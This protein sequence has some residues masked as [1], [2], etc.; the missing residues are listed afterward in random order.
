VASEIRAFAQVSDRAM[1]DYRAVKRE[2]SRKYLKSSAVPQSARALRAA[3]SP[4]PSRNVVGVGIAEKLVDN[5]PAGVLSIK[6]LVRSK[7]PESDISTS[8]ALPKMV[9]GLPTDVEEVGLI[10][11]LARKSAPARR[12]SSRPAKKAAAGMPDPRQKIRPAQPGCS[13]GFR[14]PS[15]QFVM[16]GTFGAL[17]RD[18]AGLYVLSNNHVLADEDQLAPGAPIFQPGLLDGGNPATDQIAELTRAV[19]LITTANMKV[20]GAVARA[21]RANLV[22]DEI[23]F[24]GRPNGT[25]Q[26][27]RDMIVHKF[28]RTT[29]YRA[30]RVESVDFDLSLDYTVGTV[31]FENQVSIRGLN[32]QPFSDAGDSGSAILERSSGNVVAL[33]FAGTRDNTLTFANHIDEVL[34]ALAVEL[35]T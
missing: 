8:Q 29:G 17:V 35:V 25:A 30:G 4:T 14:D 10:R 28:G 24:I 6:F 31:T 16:A 11:P 23:L 5:K 27:A 3:V 2:L 15:N 34:Q 32:G 22:S 33:L 12:R 20:D 19:K 1:T 21:L 9:D 18:R 26:A 13:V 7:F